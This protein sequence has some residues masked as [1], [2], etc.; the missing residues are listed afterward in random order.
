MAKIQSVSTLN[1][2]RFLKKKESDS[3]TALKDDYAWTC[4]SVSVNIH[5]RL[6]V[7]S[8]TGEGKEPP[9]DMLT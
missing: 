8:F 9:R 5:H 3:G 6:V 2:N 4:S 7:G 1:M